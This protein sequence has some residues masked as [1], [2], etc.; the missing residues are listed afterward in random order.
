LKFRLNDRVMDDRTLP[1]RLGTIWELRPCGRA[2]VI[3]D[4]TEGEPGRKYSHV[5][6]KHLKRATEA[7]Q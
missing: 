3:W 6:L 7:I 1:P 2:S 4:G 5:K